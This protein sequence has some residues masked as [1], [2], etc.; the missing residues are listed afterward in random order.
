VNTS[1]ESRRGCACRPVC[2]TRLSARADGV[3]EIRTRSE[4]FQAFGS[5]APFAL[6]LCVSH[7][8]PVHKGAQLMITRR[9]H[10]REFRLRPSKRVNAIVSYV[11]AVVAERTGVRLHAMVVMSN[12]WHVCLSDPEGRVCEFTRDCHALIARMVNAAHG[13][14][15]S[16]WSREQ[17]S[18]VAC[19]MPEDLLAR[20][21]YTMANP[22][23]AKLVAHG[24]N[25]PGVR[26]AWPAKAR[27]VA[28]PGGFFRSKGMGGTWP[29]AAALV[30]SRPPGFDELTDEQLAALLQ[31]AIEEREEMFRRQAQRE[32]K[33][34]MGRRDVLAQSRHR[35][36]ETREERFLLSPRVA[37]RNK[38]RRVERLAQ[39]RAWR[40]AY[41]AA[42]E[43][44]R[45]GDRSA[46]FP[47]GTYKMRLL[48]GASCVLE[49]G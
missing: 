30:M 17:T 34:F 46:L 1:C 28:Q 22:V 6:T 20:I 40:V 13:E 47:R 45:G 3:S 36:P 10:G 33:R 7:A 27:M 23:E 12:H 39:E 41:K 32:G 24:K 8:R 2:R 37:C 43:R 42:L 11:V 9:M 44:W 49:P 21:A 5:G 31:G 48:H 35:R 15:E 4:Y 38:W 26:V 29:G 16:I 18:H 25:W 14:F 19:V